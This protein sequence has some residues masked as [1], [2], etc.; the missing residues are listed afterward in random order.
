MAARRAW[1][2]EVPSDALRYLAKQPAA[3]AAPWEQSE[4]VDGGDDNG[5]GDDYLFKDQG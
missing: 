3:L 4:L 2:H 1:P 5:D